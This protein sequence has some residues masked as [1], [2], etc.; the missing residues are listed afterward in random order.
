MR[1]RASYVSNSSSSSFIAIGRRITSPEKLLKQ[2]ATVMLYVKGAGTSGDAE[3]WS[4]IL[5]EGTWSI[6]SDP[7]CS[8]FEANRHRAKLYQ[9][10]AYSKDGKLELTEDVTGEPIIFNRDY[11]SPDNKDQLLSFLE[12]IYA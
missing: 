8:W 12:D 10:F 5:S 11:S 7:G 6:L 3:D 1:I 2:G 4:M 9:L